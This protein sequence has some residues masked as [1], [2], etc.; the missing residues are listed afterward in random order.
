MD[1]RGTSVKKGLREQPARPGGAM[2][3]YRTIGW[4]ARGYRWGIARKKRLLNR[5]K[6]F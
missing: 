4:R 6:C 2:P 1:S 5:E 3:S